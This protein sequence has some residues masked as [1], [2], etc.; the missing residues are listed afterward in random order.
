MAVVGKLFY[1]GL[2]GLLMVW[3]KSS[4][5]LTLCLAVLPIIECGVMKSLAIIIALFIA[6]LI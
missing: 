5:L 2:K 1:R 6:P 3:F 4:F